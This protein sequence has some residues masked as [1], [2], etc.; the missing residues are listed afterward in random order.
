MT[1]PFPDDSIERARRYSA[2]EKQELERQLGEMTSTEPATHDPKFCVLCRSG[3]HERGPQAQP[4]LIIRRA[5]RPAT[6]NKIGG[7]S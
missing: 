4:N 6:Q 5:L 7:E 2:E 3:G 1:Q